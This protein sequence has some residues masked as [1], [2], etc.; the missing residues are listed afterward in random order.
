MPGRGTD[1]LRSVCDP[2]TEC[3]LLLRAVCVKFTGFGL[4]GS[5]FAHES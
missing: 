3:G 2:L 5:R 1:T 4:R